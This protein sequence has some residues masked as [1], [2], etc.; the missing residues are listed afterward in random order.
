V[1]H[2]SQNIACV[3]KSRRMIL[4][5]EGAYATY[6]GEWC[7]WGYVGETRGKENTWRT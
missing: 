7:V 1:L 3:I 6:P 5:G 4:A 2:S